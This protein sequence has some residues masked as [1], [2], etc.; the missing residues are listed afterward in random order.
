MW[1]Y[2]VALWLLASV[3]LPSSALAQQASRME[4]GHG[5][6]GMMGWPGAIM[7][8]LGAALVLAAIGALVAAA[9]FLV[10]R[11]NPAHR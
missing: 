10:R 9:V 6:M 5:M 2:P 4:C 7:M 1:I 8:V 11:S 3:L